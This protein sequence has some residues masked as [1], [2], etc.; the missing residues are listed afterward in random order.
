MGAE[1]LET[2]SVEYKRVSEKKKQLQIMI[3]EMKADIRKKESLI[4][5]LEAD[6]KKIKELPQEEGKINI[7]MRDC[8]V[9]L[10]AIRD[11]GAF[12]TPKYATQSS[13]N[14]YKVEKSIFESYINR[15]SELTTTEFIAYCRQFSI[16]REEDNKILFSS[17][18]VRA[19]FIPKK[20][21]DE[22]KI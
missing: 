6:L 17:G 2:E 7:F 11:E 9:V 22:M 14:Y 4:S 19:Y 13:Q 12:M 21:I 10:G 3:H 18:K 1:V 5:E 15:L 16:L 20:I 8:C